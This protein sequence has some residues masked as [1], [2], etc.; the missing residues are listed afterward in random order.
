MMNN[1]DLIICGSRIYAGHNLGNDDYFVAIKGKKILA[2]GTLEEM[3]DYIGPSTRVITLNEKQ[4]LMPGFFENHTHLIMAGMYQKCINL[5]KAKSEEEAAR[6]VAEYA[7]GIPEDEWIIGFKWYHLYWDKKVLPTTT[8]LDKYI[9]DRPVYLLNAEAHGAWVN[10]AALE[11]SGI[12]RD[13]P[14]P[15][16]GEIMHDVDGNPS[17]YLFEAAQGLAAKYAF[18][19]TPMKEEEYINIYLEKARSYGITSIVD[20]LPFFGV[21]LG[22]YRT[23]YNMGMSDKLTSRVH[24]APDLCGN[25]DETKKAMDM[26]NSEKYQISLLKGFVDGVST[27][28]TALLVEPYSDKPSDYGKTLMDLDE[29][30]LCVEDAHRRGMSVRLH[31]CADGSVR[32][33]MDAFEGAISKYG[34]TGARHAIE[35]CEVVH[36]DDVSRFSKLGVIASMQPEHLAITDD[37]ASNPF[38]VRFG[39]ERC[40]LSFPIKTLMDSGATVCFGSDCPVVDNNP[41][42]EIYRAITRLYNDGE[43]KGGWNP[44]EKISVEEALHAYTF[45]PAYAVKRD[46]ELGTI[47]TGKYADMVVVDR[48]LFNVTP[49]EIRDAKVLLTV[50]DGNIVFERNA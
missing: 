44:Q 49:D 50:M 20:M 29:M 26:F 36:P 40:K 47:E 31:A 3:E 11:L 34:D 23:F 17:G 24:A 22:S 30:K 48:D 19:M 12:T 35:H 8:Y 25:L 2:R 37:F 41:F 9:P 42:L 15:D 21:N 45:A 18:N 46:H 10:S 1:A 4:L 43:P 39:E 16:F 13:T 33:A 32:A 6:M 27:T 7:K 38:P 28:Y 14:D 5:E